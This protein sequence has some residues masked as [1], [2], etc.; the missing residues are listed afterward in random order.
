MRKRKRRNGLIAL[1]LSLAL[2]SGCESGR[3][4]SVRPNVSAEIDECIAD[5]LV[6]ND[7]PECVSG[8]LT[9]WYVLTD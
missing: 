5:F 2:L 9:Q 4:E 1:S 7:Y 3:V 8:A 6:T